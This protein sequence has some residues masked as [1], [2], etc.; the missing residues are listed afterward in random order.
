MMKAKTA[1]MMFRVLG[2]G[3]SAGLVAMD[4]NAVEV[5]GSIGNA[6]GIDVYRVQCTGTSRRISAN[7]ADVDPQ[8]YPLFHVT[9][10]VGGNRAVRRMSGEYL[11]PGEWATVFRPAGTGPFTGHVLITDVKNLG[12]VDYKTNINCQAL[13]GANQP[14]VITRTQNQ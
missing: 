11:V 5:T 7:V 1:A 4:A 3:I 6:V 2:I 12:N 10:F 13:A 8:Q 14:T 9:V